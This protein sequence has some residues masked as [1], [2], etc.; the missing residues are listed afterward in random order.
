[1]VPFT[2]FPE[3]VPAWGGRARPG[4]ERDGEEGRRQRRPEQGGPTGLHGSF[5]SAVARGGA[6]VTA[7]PILGLDRGCAGRTAPRLELG[8]ETLPLGDPV[9]ERS[10][11]GLQARGRRLRLHPLLQV[12]ELADPAASRPRG[13]WEPTGPQASVLLARELAGLVVGV[14][15]ADLGPEALAV[16]PELLD[17]E[18][19]GL[20]ERREGRG[21]P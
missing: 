8:E 19:L 15:L 14:E 10:V 3:I 7:E 12:L 5:T 16:G 17:G 6:A 20:G 13:C 4:G 11:Q 18:V 21:G 9:L 1:M 2:T